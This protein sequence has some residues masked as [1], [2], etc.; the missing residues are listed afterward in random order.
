MKQRRAASKRKLYIIIAA[1]VLL[2]G[3]IAL[4]INL[5]GKSDDKPANDHK[6]AEQTAP[7]DD[8]TSD[9]NGTNGAPETEPEQ[10]T[11]IDPTLVGAIDIIPAGLAVSYLK[12]VGGFEYEVLR[13]E[14]GRKYVE[15]RNASLIG[16]K[17]DADA[18]AF[19]SIIESPSESEQA[20][21]AKTTTVDGVKYGLSL[22]LPTCTSD[23]SLLKNYQDAFSKPF[24]LLKRL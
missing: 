7:K 12:G 8:D 2:V 1:A 19:A 5:A 23:E 11:P 14:G 21:L 20:T 9:Q 10:D 3:A 15:L 22:A 18:G 6:G 4:I 17:C 24:H 13:A 16:T